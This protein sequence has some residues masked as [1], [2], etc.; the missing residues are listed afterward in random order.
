M[1]DLCAQYAMPDTV[2]SLGGQ[3]PV[4]SDSLLR[5]GWGSDPIHA[6]VARRALC[7]YI[8]RS[9]R[10]HARSYGSSPVHCVMP[11]LADS[12]IAS[13]A[14]FQDAGAWLASPV[15]H[16]LE[17]GADI[18]SLLLGERRNLAQSQADRPDICLGRHHEK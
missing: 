6:S 11:N 3:Q 8:C 15:G 18:R 1:T 7:T 4:T 13:V 5:K 17:V 14:E 12:H 2:D 16:L 10:A 9:A